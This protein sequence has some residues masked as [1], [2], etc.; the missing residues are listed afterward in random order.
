MDTA[1]LSKAGILFIILL[2]SLA[3]HEFGHAW[4]ADKRGD[5]LPRQ[6]GRVT[7]DPTAHLDPIG[8]FLIPGI[9]ILTSVFSSGMPFALLGWGKPVQISLPNRDT[10]RLDDILITLAGPG[11]NLLLA[12]VFSIAAGLFY[13]HGDTNAVNRFFTPAIRLNVTLAVFNLVPIPPLDGSHLLRHAIGMSDEIYFRL[14][15]NG[16]WVLLI[17]INVSFFRELLSTAI[18]ASATPFFHIANF[19]TQ[20]FGT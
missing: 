3:L 6:Q 5:P 10:R 1:Q 14:A 8:S 12:L 16:W 17:L 11:V 2:C 7:L 18:Y 19:V 15:A 20:L 9:M 4:M 13:A